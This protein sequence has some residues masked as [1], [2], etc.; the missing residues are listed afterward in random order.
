MYTIYD[1]AFPNI[2][3]V[4]FN[5]KPDIVRNYRNFCTH[6]FSDRCV[7]LFQTK[8]QWKLLYTKR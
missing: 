6:N 8:Y 7:C 1:E 5:K 3:I 4:K 2:K